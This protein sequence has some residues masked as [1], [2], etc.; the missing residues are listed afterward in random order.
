MF[1]I[2]GKPHAHFFSV[3][4]RSIFGHW[5]YALRPDNLFAQETAI[6]CAHTTHLVD[7]CHHRSACHFAVPVDNSVQGHSE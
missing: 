5:D 1:V 7:G 2:C 3:V 6:V 4:M